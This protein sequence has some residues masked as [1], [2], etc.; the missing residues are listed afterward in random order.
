MIDLEFIKQLKRLD[1]LAK[2]KV[3]SSY[4]GSRRSVRQGR[5][6]EPVDNREY[7]PGDDIRFID[8]KVYGRT[9]KLFIKRFEEDRSLT[10]HLLVDASN[11]MDFSGQSERKY[12]FAA[13]LA[14]GF[15]YLVTKENEKFALCC[16]SDRIDG[17]LP[18][19][20]GRRQFHN[21]IELLNRQQTQGKT[22]IGESL[23]KYASTIRSRS[24]SIVIS[25]FLQPLDSINK[26]LLE[27]SRRSKSLIVIHVMDPAEK[28]LAMQGDV[29]LHDLETE[30]VK[31]IFI[32]PEMRRDYAVRFMAHVEKLRKICDEIG[33][34]FFSVSSDDPIFE[35]FF[36]ITHI[37]SRGRRRG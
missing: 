9:E 3:I 28:K 12:D 36:E 24:L 11:S 21:A 27:M 6:I 34:D 18:P 14:L 26:G 23:K 4:A 29:K 8:W 25:D 13:K 31:K 35:T 33:A 15:A 1:L 19:K 30:G 16:F 20:R 17:L 22:A 10:T 5:G 7:F 2:K 32:T 37:A